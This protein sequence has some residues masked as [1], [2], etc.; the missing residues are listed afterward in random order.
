[1]A[2]SVAEHADVRRINRK[3]QL[4]NAEILISNGSPPWS[5]SDPAGC[6]VYAQFDYRNF[7]VDSAHV[8]VRAAF[9]RSMLVISK[10]GGSRWLGNIAALAQ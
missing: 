2:K 4:R 6:R 5:E 7:L 8:H 9:V 10:R 3:P 1:V